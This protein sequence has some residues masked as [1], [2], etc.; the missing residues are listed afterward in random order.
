MV[1]NKEAN[2][3]E[4]SQTSTV[5]SFAYFII[6]IHTIKTALKNPHLHCCVT[7]AKANLK[8]FYSYL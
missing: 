6:I 8:S 2:T 3:K 1:S 5:S 4:F 7:T